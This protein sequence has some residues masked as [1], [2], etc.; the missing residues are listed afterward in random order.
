MTQ[1][2]KFDAAGD[3][4]RRFVPELKDLPDKDIHAPWEAPEGVLKA[5]GI[6]LGKTYPK[7]MMDHSKPERIPVALTRR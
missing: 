5:A 1:S 2:R 3:Y 6:E 7:P 4:I